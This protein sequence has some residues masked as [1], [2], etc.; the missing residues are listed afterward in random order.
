MFQCMNCN[1]MVGDNVKNCPFCGHYFTPDEMKE[2]RQNKEMEEYE[3]KHAKGAGLKDKRF[4]KMLFII[5]AVVCAV[6]AVV[7]KTVFDRYTL[8]MVFFGAMMVFCVAV[9][10]TIIKEKL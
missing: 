9:W 1:E 2:L 4:W 8:M 6:L 10:V 5:L 7:A 3:K